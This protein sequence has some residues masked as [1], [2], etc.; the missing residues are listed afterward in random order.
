MLTSGV[1]NESHSHG[2]DVYQN[3]ISTYWTESLVEIRIQ[4]LGFLL[5]RLKVRDKM[6]K[7]YDRRDFLSVYIEI[8]GCNGY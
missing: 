3:S 7:I 5:F 1:D 2:N 4:V 8:R 6:L